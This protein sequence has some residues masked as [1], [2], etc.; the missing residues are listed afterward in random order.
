M[1]RGVV[2]LT[3]SFC[4]PIMA[5]A[6]ALCPESNAPADVVVYPDR[7]I[8]SGVEEYSSHPHVAALRTSSP[9]EVIELREGANGN[10]EYQGFSIGIYDLYQ[11]QRAYKLGGIKQV[12]IRGARGHDIIIGR[13]NGGDALAIV[14]GDDYGPNEHLCFQNLTFIVKERSGVIF[15]QNP[16]AQRYR[17][18]HFDRVTI[19]PDENNPSAGERKWGM[20]LYS[21]MNFSFTN[22]A[23]YDIHKEH[24]L[25]FTDL[26]GLTDISG[27]VFSGAGRNAVQVRDDASNMT[28]PTPGVVLFEDNFVEDMGQFDGASSFTMA[29]GE[30]TNFYI[31]D[32]LFLNGLHTGQSNGGVVSWTHSAFG[33]PYQV[34]CALIENNGFYYVNSDRTLMQ[35]A[36]LGRLMLRN[37][38]LISPS[39]TAVDLN[40]GGG[41][42]IG[43]IYLQGNQFERSGYHSLHQVRMNGSLLSSSEI[44]AFEPA[45]NFSWTC[46]QVGEPYTPVG[47]Y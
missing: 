40:Y 2:I 39:R 47:N 33:Y 44:G 12:L 25:Y 6:E 37:N 19:R 17:D 29:G 10:G 35:F 41:P 24:S 28:G 43:E 1:I 3:V 32:N 5:F 42:N 22:G 4:I 27:N 8:R 16:G 45:Q 18:I 23:I 36:S 13:G 31:R 9:G 30:E 38:L 21:T 14:N 20:R 11:A 34:R 46:P 26:G 7:Y 15:Y